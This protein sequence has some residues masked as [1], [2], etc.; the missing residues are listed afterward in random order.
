LPTEKKITDTVRQS[1]LT[2]F[3]FG[4]WKE[5]DD[6]DKENQPE[7][8]EKRQK[9]DSPAR[10]KQRIRLESEGKYEQDF[11]WLIVTPEGYF[12]SIYQKYNQRQKNSSNVKTTL[13][14]RLTNTI[15]QGLMM[16]SIHGPDDS[17]FDFRTAMNILVEK[18][19]ESTEKLKLLKKIVMKSLLLRKI[20]RERRIKRD[21]LKIK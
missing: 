5:R 18:A 16:V 21:M 13:W 9:T 11:K 19:K 6:G 8:A 1:S 7:L 2:S 3:F 10:H 15:L 17:E 4:K 14:S 20:T 12:C